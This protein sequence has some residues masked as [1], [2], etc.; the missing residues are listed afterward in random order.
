MV[1]LARST[2]PRARLLAPRC[3]ATSSAQ[4]K[5]AVGTMPVPDR[6]LFVTGNRKK[7]EEVMSLVV[8]MLLRML[9]SASLQKCHYQVV[10]IIEAGQQ[11]PFHIEGISADLPELQVRRRHADSHDRTHC[12]HRVNPR[13]LLAKSAASLPSRYICEW[14]ASCLPLSLSSTHTQPHI[15]QPPQLGSAVMVEDTSLCFN[16]MHGLPG[17]YIKWFLE[18]L[19]HDGLNKMLGTW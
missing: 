3:L 5:S 14:R 7:L 10:A 9:T 1:C 16:A 12:R 17:P 6:I 15:Q 11:L 18:K 8:A 2:F 4:A 13:T 19:G